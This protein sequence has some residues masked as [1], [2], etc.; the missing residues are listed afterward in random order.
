MAKRSSSKRKLNGSGTKRRGN[1]LSRDAHRAFTKRLAKL[2][3][4]RT[5]NKMNTELGLSQASWHMYEAGKAFPNLVT[6]GKLR[7]ALKVDLNWLV[8]GG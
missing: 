2:R 6:L 1:H 8:N 4:K 5:I 7:R 3:G